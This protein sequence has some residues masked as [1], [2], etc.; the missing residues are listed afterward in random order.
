MP[1]NPERTRFSFWRPKTLL[2]VVYLGLIVIAANQ[3]LDVD[4]YVSISIIAVILVASAVGISHK[5]QTSK[6]VENANSYLRRY[7]WFDA[8]FLVSAVGLFLCIPVL[9][10]MGARDFIELFVVNGILCIVLWLM[11]RLLV[12]R[13]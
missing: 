4:Y 8:L 11:I 1:E 12:K 9:Y 13:R 7:D 5:Y 6:Y 2:L 10:L 3:F